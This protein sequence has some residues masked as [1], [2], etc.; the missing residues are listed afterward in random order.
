LSGAEVRAI[1]LDVDGV[2]TDGGLW[3]G[4]D[5]EEFKRFSF[6]DI[7]GVAEG[8]RAGLVFALISGEASPLVDRFAQKMRIQHVHKGCRDKAQAMRD[9]AAATGIPLEA[10]AFMGDDVNDL[11]AMALAG[12]SAA[13]ANAH[14][15]VRGVVDLVTVAPGGDGAVRELVDTLLAR[16]R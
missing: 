5:G 4:P 11:P 6:R 12:F 7:M 8:T 2:L 16:A 10:I 13:P 14:A 9:L 3:W 1:A 15:S